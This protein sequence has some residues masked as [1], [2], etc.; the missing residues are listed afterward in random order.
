MWPKLNT[1]KH[2]VTLVACFTSFIG[3]AQNPNYDPDYNGD[4]FIGVT[5][6][7]SLL[8]IYNSSVYDEE[9]NVVYF[10]DLPVIGENMSWDGEDEAQILQVPDDAD[11]LIW[12]RSNL[13]ANNTVI[14]LALSGARQR[15][16]YEGNTF[17]QINDTLLELSVYFDV[18]PFPT[19]LLT[20]TKIDG[21]WF[22]DIRF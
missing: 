6:L 13:P 7:T 19:L 3:L 5:D 18:P 11:L 20:G 2:F 4:A 1:M 10:Q 9:Y 17:L 8:S 15:L 14:H 16:N 12:D 21:L 22:V